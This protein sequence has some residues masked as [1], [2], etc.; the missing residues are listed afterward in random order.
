M[1]KDKKVVS[2]PDEGSPEARREKFQAMLY[3]KL[4]SIR[5]N[6]INEST[7]ITYKAYT[8]ALYR[9]YMKN[10]KKNEA[11]IRG[12]SEFLYKVSNPYKRILKYYANIPLFRWNLTPIID[13]SNYDKEKILSDYTKTCKRLMTMNIPNEMRKVMILTL[14]DGAY[15]GQVYED[16]NSFC[17]R[18][19]PSDYCKIDSIQGGVHNIAFNMSYFTKHMS[20]LEGFGSDMVSLYDAYLENTTNKWASLDPETTI[21]IRADNE[22]IIETL[23]GLLGIFE[24]LIDLI[25]SRGIQNTKDIVENY[26]LI[27]QKLPTFDSTMEVDDFSIEMDTALDF[28][29]KLL[30]A[31]PENVGVALSPL[32]IDTIDFKNSDNQN[33]ILSSSMKSLFDDS[34]VSQMLFNGDKS[35]STGLDASIKTDIA[36]A[37][38][39]VENIER[40]I[41]RYLVLT[42]TTTDFH[43]EILRMNIFNQT[44]YVNNELKLANAGVPNKLKLAAASGIPPAISIA[45]N[46]LEEDI[47]G[48]SDIWKPLQSS[49]TTAG[50]S[51]SNAGSDENTTVTDKTLA[52]QESATGL[53]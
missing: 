6:D 41:R 5:I 39:I 40:W 8:K 23:P 16:K 49:Y 20:Q 30:D 15:Y 52:N 50:T 19:L 44:D 1:E 28:Y 11:N 51:K 47:L 34:G 18:T 4:N 53:E 10:L 43:F 9:T 48:L 12:M 38:E 33:N 45:A 29:G 26:K 7:T 46:V 24:G 37:W 14:R 25:D 27:I 35:G 32:E 3:E 31:V 2:M 21:C 36:F 13:I 17:I 42:G 22:N